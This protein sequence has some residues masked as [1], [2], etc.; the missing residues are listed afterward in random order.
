M[1]V[2]INRG[3]PRRAPFFSNLVKGRAEQITP[4]GCATDSA[5]ELPDGV[6]GSQNAFPGIVEK[7]NWPGGNRSGE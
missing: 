3:D 1:A 2:K 7:F 6:T 4:N 5:P